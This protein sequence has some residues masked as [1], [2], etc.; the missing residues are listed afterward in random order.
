MSDFLARLDDYAATGTL[1]EVEWVLRAAP[2]KWGLGKIHIWLYE[3]DVTQCGR[4]LTTCPGL[5]GPGQLED[6][7]CRSC[8]RSYETPKRWEERRAEA[9]RRAA[10]Y[11]EKWVARWGPL[12][13]QEAY[14]QH[15]TSP[16]WQE[17]RRKVFARCGGMCEH[18]CGRPATQAHHLTYERPGDESLPISWGSAVECHESIHGIGAW[19]A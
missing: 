17:L 16:E 7:S 9:E 6:V 10:I 3:E 11:W 5:V 15:L 19:P 13:W 8:T 1:P 14:E 4:N 18:R 12:S 2:H